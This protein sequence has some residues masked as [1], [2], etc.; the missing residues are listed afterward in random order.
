[1]PSF[2]STLPRRIAGVSTVRGVIPFD[3][4]GLF[5]ASVPFVSTVQAQKGLIRCECAET[6]QEAVPF[7][8]S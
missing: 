8:L 7:G 5:L 3:D 4:W 2:L 6:T 1:M